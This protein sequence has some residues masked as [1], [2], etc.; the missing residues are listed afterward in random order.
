MLALKMIRQTLFD[1]LDQQI[2][3]VAYYHNGRPIFL[4]ADETPAIAVFIE[5]AETEDIDLCGA[6][7]ECVLNVVVY[8]KST[9]PED[10]IDLIM[11]RVIQKLNSINRE[12][13]ERF[14]LENLAYA[15]DE[16]QTQWI[17]GTLQYRI[18]FY[19]TIEDDEL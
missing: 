1:L 9:L 4:N 7:W 15:Y 18:G 16:Q 11:E 19:L 12:N 5:G 8:Q 2:E 13:F 3:G 14:S 6:Y 10:R 17:A